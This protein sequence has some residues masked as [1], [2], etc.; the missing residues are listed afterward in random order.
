MSFEM[1]SELIP[2]V[3]FGAKSTDDP[4]GSIP[5]QLAESEA[6]ALREGRV[7]AGRYHDENVSGFKQSRGPGLKRAIAKAIEAAERYGKAELWAQHS[8]RFARGDGR[9]A[10]HLGGLYFELLEHG[11]TLRTVQDDLFTDPRFAPML[12]GVMGMRNTEDSRRKSEAVKSGKRRQ[13]ERGQRQGGPVPDGYIRL[14]N[15]VGEHVVIRYDLDPERA[16]IIERIFMLA[17]EG[18]PPAIIARR[19]NAEGV[20]TKRGGTWTRRRIQDTLS[21][22]WYA[23]LATRGR[24]VRGTQVQERPGTQRAL[25]SVELFERVRAQFAARDK[26]AGSNRRGRPNTRHVLAGLMRCACGD[27]M[28]ARTS[29]YARKDGTRAR[30]YDCQNYTDA[31]G[32]CDMHIPAEMIERPVLRNLDDLSVDYDG[33]IRS[34]AS[35]HAT[36]RQAIEERIAADR[37]LLVQNDRDAEAV[38]EDYLRMRR[39]GDRDASKLTAKVQKRLERERKQIELRIAEQEAIL[40]DMPTNAPTDAMMDLANDLRDALRGVSDANSSVLEV[41]ARLKRVIDHIVVERGSLEIPDLPQGTKAYLAGSRYVAPG[42]HARQYVIRVH[43]REDA[44]RGYR[45]WVTAAAAPDDDDRVVIPP[46]KPIP[47]PVGNRRNTHAYLWT[48]WNRPALRLSQP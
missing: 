24:T 18:L 22:G 27:G 37:V 12:A 19:L 7:I 15:V 33:W 21:N 20:R 23:G 10:R 40:A 2:A 17:D 39:E 44:V 13:F 47:V 14:K 46:V 11:V 8:D 48:K 32:K 36:Q 6:A 34:L 1:T 28:Y 3:L 35:A 26:A 25:V 42:P 16:P 5:D 31:T 9:V 29:S 41:N 45:S 4:N 43:L 30:H 38:E